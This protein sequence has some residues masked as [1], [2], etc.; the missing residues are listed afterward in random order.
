MDSWWV[1]G[2]VFVYAILYLGIMTGAIYWQRWRHP[3]RAPTLEPYLR[4][5]GESLRKS[6]EKMND[7]EPGMVLVCLLGPPFSAGILFLIGVS[8]GLRSW[9]QFYF[10]FGFILL[11]FMGTTVLSLI[12]MMR[13]FNRW[14]NY[15]LGFYGER[16]VAQ[17]LN[18]LMG[19][20]FWIYHDFLL[21]SS[22]RP[23][24]IDH[25][26]VGP[27]GVYAVETKTRRKR[28]RTDGGA[29]HKLRYDGRKLMF[30][31]GDDQHGLEQTRR[32]TRHLKNLLEK[33]TG[34]PSIPV[35]GI[36]TLPG[37]FVVADKDYQDPAVLSPKAIEPFLLRQPVSNKMDPQKIK[38]I[39]FAI[40]ERN[41]VI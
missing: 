2:A 1:Y 4:P 36:L 31:F 40:E 11:V 3:S 13:H 25:I 15:D 8:S 23:S 18:P 7:Q 30:P 5:P 41:K 20:G 22:G 34:I 6:L 17:L 10:L 39:C 9:S 33:A 32:N 16:Y 35:R 37:W 19:K 21:D 27:S 38:Q 26:L 24:N 29:D 12:F 14:R 28:K